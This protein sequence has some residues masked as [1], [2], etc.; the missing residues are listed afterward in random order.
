MITTDA[1]IDYDE[2]IDYG[3]HEFCQECQVC[4]NRCPGRAK[5]HRRRKGRVLPQQR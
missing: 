2:P 4:V 1:P 3:V 5:E